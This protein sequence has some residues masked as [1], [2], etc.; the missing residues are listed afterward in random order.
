MSK[1]DADKDSVRIDCPRCATPH[2]LTEFTVQPVAWAFDNPHT[3]LAITCHAC[4]RD[5]VWAIDLNDGPPLRCG[6]IK[7]LVP[8]DIVE[9]EIFYL[10]EWVE[11]II[12]KANAKGAL[13]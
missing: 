4:Q 2:R 3:Q 13:A 8:T 10:S 11:G 6:G 5:G 7:D 9:G 1:H 12:F